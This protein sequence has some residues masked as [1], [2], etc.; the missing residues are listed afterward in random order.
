MS[1]EKEEQSRTAPSRSNDLAGRGRRSE[2]Y[3]SPLMSFS[4]RGIPWLGKELHQIALVRVGHEAA[5]G[6]AEIGDGHDGLDGVVVH[7]EL[8]G[9]Q[10]HAGARMAGDLQG[11]QVQGLQGQDDPEVGGGLDGHQVPGAAYGLEAQ[12]HGFRAAGGDDQFPRVQVAIVAEGPLGDLD[13]QVLLAAT[14]SPVTSG[15]LAFPGEL[16]PGSG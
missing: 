5:G 13:A 8:Q 1:L 10:A 12:A 7:R 6:I 2:K 16:G 11:A 14:A 4:M 9:V 15:E 3:S